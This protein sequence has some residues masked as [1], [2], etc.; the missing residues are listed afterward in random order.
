MRQQSRP[1]EDVAVSEGGEAQRLHAVKKRLPQRQFIGARRGRSPIALAD[2]AGIVQSVAEARMGFELPSVRQIDGVRRDVV[3]GGPSVVAQR[4]PC[5]WSELERTGRRQRRAVLCPGG[6]RRRSFPRRRGD[7]RGRGRR[8]F[9][10][11]LLRNAQGE[12]RRSEVGIMWGLGRLAH[13]SRSVR[14]QGGSADA[15]GGT[16][17]FVSVAGVGRS[18]RSPMHP[19]QARARTPTAIRVVRKRTGLEQTSFSLASSHCVRLARRRKPLVAGR[20]GARV[21]GRCC[22]PIMAAPD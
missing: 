14:R 12:G 20:S 19:T 9:E 5:K 4:G 15:S 16:A 13:G 11:R 7:R 2:E 1:A 22:S 21:E 3:D 17:T 18:T 6:L 10:P 8:F